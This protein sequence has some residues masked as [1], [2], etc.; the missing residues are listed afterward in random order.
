MDHLIDI[1]FVCTIVLTVAALLCVVEGYY[2]LVI[3][4]R[5]QKHIQEIKKLVSKA[6]WAGKKHEQLDKSIKDLK[7]NYL[8]KTKH[9]S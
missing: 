1:K 7:R 9:H 6:R 8:Q 2:H 3:K 4:P 5:N